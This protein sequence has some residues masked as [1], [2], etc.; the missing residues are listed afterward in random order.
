MNRLAFHVVHYA[1][2]IG[3]CVLLFKLYAS[4]MVQYNF[5]PSILVA[6]A[7]GWLLF[8]VPYLITFFILL[9]L[10]RF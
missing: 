7:I 9:K 2:S 10:W 8:I 5:T 1:V 4:F 6:S 3:V